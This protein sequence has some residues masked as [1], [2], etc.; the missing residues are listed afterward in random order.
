M[1]SF[2]KQIRWRETLLCCFF[3][4]ICLNTFLPAIA[5]TNVV[6][7]LD[8]F[9]DNQGHWAE[10]QL[11]K[12][13][14]Q[15]L[16]P[17]SNDEVI[18]DQLI[19]RTEFFNLLNQVFGYD[20]VPENADIPLSRQEAADIIARIFPLNNAVFSDIQEHNY[21][22]GFDDMGSM[23]EPDLNGANYVVG[24][25]WM[26]GYPDRTLQLTRNITWAEVISVLDRAAGTIYNKPGIY[27]PEQGEVMLEGNVVINSEGITLRNTVINGDLFLMKGVGTGKV[28]LNNVT[29]NGVIAKESGVSVEYTAQDEQKYTKE[30][31]D[32]H[33]PGFI[34]GYPQV[35]NVKFNQ[36][37]LIIKTDEAGKAFYVVVED[38]AAAPT[39]EQ[40]KAG[41]DAYGNILADNRRGAV[42]LLEYLEARVSL[43]GFSAAT[44]YDVYIVAEDHLQNVQDEVTK[45]ELTT[46]PARPVTSITVTGADELT[47][48]IKNAT[49]QMNVALL[50]TDS[51]DSGIT[52]SVEP[53]TGT[54]SISP[55]GILTGLSAGTVTVKATANDGYG[56]VG[57][58]VIEVI[59]PVTEINVAGEGGATT[60]AVEGATLQM[61]GTVSPADATNPTV[62][63]SVLTIDDNESGMTGRASIDEHG[64]LTF[65]ASGT[66]KVIATANDGSEVTGELIITLGGPTLLG[67]WNMDEG[68]GETVY[69]SSGFENHGTI[70]GDVDWQSTG[71]AGK[72]LFFSN[73]RVCI[74]YDKMIAPRTAITVETW[75]KF[76]STS[77]WQRVIAKSRKPQFD[78]LFLMG[79]GN[80]IRF[81][82]GREGSECGLSGGV[83]STGVWHH[84]VGTYDG[85][86]LRIY[87]D[88]QQKASA[89]VTG[90]IDTHENALYLGH[91]G[92]AE[93]LWGCLDEVA[94]YNYA[95]TPEEV[96]AHYQQ[97]GTW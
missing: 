76:N 34:L 65:I 83:I 57:S 45:V 4:F 85:S 89:A 82:I 70:Y 12:W 27:G 44:S 72:C 47:S 86:T 39:A 23:T 10:T 55:T 43:A 11:K 69:D 8:L 93:S 35:L 51:D 17:D 88:G 60:I 25:G 42:S 16:V 90:L 67:R 46:N 59:A 22:V 30:R 64:L 75:A 48:V 1:K 3:C 36:A 87:V 37:D 80:D 32:R 18:P 28:R 53:G 97:P 26:G 15:D 21:L 73:G 31:K 7:V 71:V 58:M 62:T 61:H 38:G 24:S 77:S 50:P 29:T 78:Y 95:L 40:I 63:W 68:S 6:A 13:A 52:W 54:A 2:L 41:E 14:E 91:D 96:L 92:Q 81:I 9:T 5:S 94:L 79:D 74:P 56:A 20:D 49:L 19:T 84:L 66:V 33:A